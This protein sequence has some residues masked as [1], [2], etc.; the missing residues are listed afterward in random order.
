MQVICCQIDV[1]WEDRRANHQKVREM[2]AAAEPAP[3]SLVVL[4]E[5]FASGFSMDVAAV[6]QGPQKESEQF[7]AGLAR[8]HGVYVLGGVVNACA[9]G[10]AP[11]RRAGEAGSVPADRSLPAG[12]GS[13]PADLRRGRNEAVVF[14]PGGRE[15]ARYCKLHPFTAAG[16]QRHYECGREVV[17][18][19]WEGF[20][21]SPF[22]CY[23][24]R[25][26]EAFRV[27][28]GRGAQVLAVLANWPK[29]REGHW[30]AL[31]R[32]RAIENQAYVVG[33]NRCGSDPREAYSG[34]S[35]VVDP[36]GEVVAAGGI[37]ECIVRA[38]VDVAAV[39]EWRK[40]FPALDDMR[41]A[42]DVPGGRED[43]QR[44]P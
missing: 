10:S 2:L 33:V 9:A 39:V 35:M 36:Q 13:A 11:P 21:V 19:G 37:E 25:F 34:G 16:E 24:L 41:D 8:E 7:M 1:V 43:L 20:T 40:R 32:A 14:D 28:A 38:E 5:M 27:A 15:L 42:G 17:C 29:A 12:A 4:P 3:R 44:R 31:L 30:A 18:F 26:P 6:A 23:D 22:I